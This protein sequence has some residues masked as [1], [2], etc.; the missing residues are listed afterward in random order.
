MA[1]ESDNSDTSEE[2][3][4]V[5][6]G[7]VLDAEEEEE[8]GEREGRG[9]EEEGGGE[10]GGGPSDDDEDDDEDDDDEGEKEDGDT[11]TSDA[12]T[13]S[14]ADDG[15]DHNAN[16]EQF[17][18]R[19][20]AIAYMK[21]NTETETYKVHPTVLWTMVTSF[22]SEKDA[23]AIHWSI[24]DVNHN[25][26]MDEKGWQ[27]MNNIMHNFFEVP[28]RSHSNADMGQD[29]EFLLLSIVVSARHADSRFHD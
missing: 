20:D 24:P 5:A 14:V 16:S 8:E 28:N 26:V 19:D 17:L 3:E 4:K 1:S 27:I 11:S 15:D 22:M 9:E 29:G 10:G 2:E 6:S 12:A 18:E 23:D 7:E 25:D 13:D 21:D